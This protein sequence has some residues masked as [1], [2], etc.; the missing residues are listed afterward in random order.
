MQENKEVFKL[1]KRV[2]YYDKQSFGLELDKLLSRYPDGSIEKHRRMPTLAYL[3]FEWLLE[4]ENKG[5]PKVATSRDISWFMN[6]LWQLNDKL[7]GNRNTES[8]ELFLRPV[9][10]N[11]FWIQHSSAYWLRGLVLQHA[12]MFPNGANSPFS[13]EFFQTTKVQLN[14]YFH[15]AAALLVGMDNEHRVMNYSQVIKALYPHFSIDT[16]ARSIRVF[17][18]F[19]EEIALF[20]A[21]KMPRSS[22]LNIVNADT[23]L[24]HCPIILNSRGLYTPDFAMLRRGL[25]ESALNHFLRLKRSGFRT[26]YGEAYEN[27]VRGCLIRDDITF[28]SED[29][30]KKRYEDHK[31]EG[32]VVD[33]FVKASSGV[34]LVEAKGV[35]PKV[36][37]LTTAD[38]RRIKHHLKDTVLRAAKQIIECAFR[39]EHDC[40]QKLPEKANRYGLIVTQGEYYLKRF[41]NIAKHI[42]ADTIANLEAK[43]GQPIPYENIF[44]CNINDFDYLTG[45][46]ATCCDFIVSFMHHCKEEDGNTET[47]KMLMLQHIES[48][49]EKLESQGQEYARA[50]ETAVKDESLLT[51]LAELVG[52]NVEYWK[53]KSKTELINKGGELMR[54]L[55][56][57][58]ADQLK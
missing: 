30:L 5:T 29:E 57:T 41:S 52:A 31:I 12:L 53:T 11:Q 4:V 54:C 56:Q 36:E 40:R 39:L 17:A 34:V 23:R 50:R 13:E 6:K 48:F 1:K 44:I 21:E 46:E 27:Y 35:V 26:R 7:G 49:F 32:K 42:A 3:L 28:D 58:S 24:I 15:I 45:T 37:T 2:R 47:S 10:N 18:M 14:D 25:S 43:F 9:I 22:T 20:L 38:P 16:I 8:V 55:A 51:E 19:P 33:A